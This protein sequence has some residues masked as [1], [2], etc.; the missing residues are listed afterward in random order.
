MA[1]RNSERRCVG[2]L[3]EYPGATTWYEYEYKCPDCGKWSAG[4]DVTLVNDD[5]TESMLCPTCADAVEAE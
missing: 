5:G 1:I 3:R 4:S 2:A